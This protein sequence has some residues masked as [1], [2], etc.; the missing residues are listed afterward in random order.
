MVPSAPYLLSI[1]FVP[2]LPGHHKWGDDTNEDQRDA[3]S[4]PQPNIADSEHQPPDDQGDP[5]PQPSDMFKY[6]FIVLIAQFI[7]PKP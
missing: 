7:S 4:G 1:V 3:D 6:R 2:R 5:Y